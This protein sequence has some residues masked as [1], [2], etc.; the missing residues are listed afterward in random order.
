MEQF[1]D[2]LRNVIK[3]TNKNDGRFGKIRDDEK[4]LSVKKLMPESV[5][6][7]RFRGTTLPYEELLITLESIIIDKVTTHSPKVKKIDTSAPMDIGMAAGADGKEAFEEG[8]NLQCKQCTREA[9]VDGT[10][11]RVP[12]GA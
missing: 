2:I 3:E 10:E 1:D 7:Y 9:K 8:W 6:T 11:E 4:T 5:L 12:L